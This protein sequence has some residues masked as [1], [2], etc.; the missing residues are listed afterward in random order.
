MKK[1]LSNPVIAKAHKAIRSKVGSAV[2]DYNMIEDGDRIMVCLSGGA[3]SYT[4]LDMLLGL[5]M[6]APIPT[7]ALAIAMPIPQVQR[8]SAMWTFKSFELAHGAS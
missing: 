8:S 5:Q 1:I 7:P 6:A 4:M 3:D 2:S